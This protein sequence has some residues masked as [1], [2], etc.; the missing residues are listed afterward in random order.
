[1]ISRHWT[2]VSKPGKSGDY[3]LHLKNVTFN[4]LKKITGFISAQILQRDTEEGVEFLVI[5]NWDNV[6]SIKQFAGNDFELA[7]VPKLVQDILLKYD[8]KVKHFDVTYEVSF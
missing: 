3:I 8:K 6:D 2:G 7:V 4:N 1:M 5:T